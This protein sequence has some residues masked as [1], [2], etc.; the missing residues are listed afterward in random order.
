M[1]TSKRPPAI[2]QQRF[3]A[4]RAEFQGLD[5]AQRFERI[6]ETNLWGADSSVSGVGSELDATAAIRERLPGLLKELGVRSLLDAPCGDHRW[7]ASL[8]LELDCYVGMDIVPS[9]IEALQQ[10]YRDDA[11]RSFL[12]GDLT[13]D[14]LPHCDLIFSRDCLVHFSFATLD[15]TVRNLKASGAVWLLT[16]TF[17]ELERN[18]DIEDADW[19]PLNFE[20]AP[21]NWPAPLEIINERC[22]EAGGAYAD[23]S[24]ALWRLKDLP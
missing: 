14:A 12:L 17:P 13:R 6:H 1:T 5:L 2:A 21:L 24:L 8:D 20:I 7:M 3:A 11:R 15:R 19:R 16:T 18:E 10:R 9:I 4:R 23:K 22:T